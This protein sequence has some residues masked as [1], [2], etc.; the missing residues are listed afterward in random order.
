M[1]A[2]AVTMTNCTSNLHSSLTRQCDERIDEDEPG[3]YFEH[4][5][6]EPVGVL[7]GQVIKQARANYQIEDP[8]LLAGQVAHVVLK[9]A[10]A[11]Q[12]QVSLHE[13]AFRNAGSSAFD[14]DDLGAMQREFDCVVPFEA[15]EIQDSTLRQGL[16]Q[17]I[18]GNLQ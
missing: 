18:C 17:K 11:G 3:G 5:L 6:E 10:C 15:S 8:V 9:E 16:P 7:R 13:L 12:A 2:I 1:L 4:R 14:A